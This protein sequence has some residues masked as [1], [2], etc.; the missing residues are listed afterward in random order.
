MIIDEYGTVTATQEEVIEYLRKN[1]DFDISSVFIIDGEEYN[2]SVDNCFP[3]LVKVKLCKDKKYDCSPEEYHKKLQ[4]TWIMP[5]EY[6]LL[7]ISSFLISKCKSEKELKRVNEELK[8]YEKYEILDIL[9]YLKYLKDVADKNNIV[10]GVGRGSSC[11]SYCLFLLK[12]HRV[13]SIKYELDIKEFL[14]EK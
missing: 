5:D 8:L 10:W 1:P 12:I 6:K 9:K 3:D 11:C 13:D 14:K 2:R 7:D 4:K